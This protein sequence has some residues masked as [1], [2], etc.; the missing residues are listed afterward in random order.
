MGQEKRGLPG[1]IALAAVCTVGWKG[2]RR[3]TSLTAAWVVSDWSIGN[4]IGE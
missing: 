3:G 2:S 1:E 4:E